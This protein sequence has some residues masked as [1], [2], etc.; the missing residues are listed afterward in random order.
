MPE[1]MDSLKIQIKTNIKELINQEKYKEAQ[2]LLDQYIKIAS[3][4][5]ENFSIQSVIYIHQGNFSEAQNIIKKGL[6]VENNNFELLFNLAYVFEQLEDFSQAYKFYKKA[7][8][9]CTDIIVEEQIN[10]KLNNLENKITKK[11]KLIFFIKHNINSFVDDIVEELSDEYE[12]RFI[13]VSDLRQIDE[14]MQWADL[15]W[16]EWCDELVAYGSKLAIA[17][18]KFI[19]CR[20]HSYEAF[21]G[22]TNQVLWDS[23]DKVIFVAEHIRKF[24]LEN[25]STLLKEKTVVIPNGIDAGKY[26]FKERGRGFKIAYVGYIN[27]KKGPML[28]LH[29]FKA[30]HDQDSRYKLYMA[31]TFQ[32]GRDVLYF[33]QMIQEWNLESSVIYQGWQ[34]SLDQ[35]LEDKNYI[36]CTSLLES[37]NLSVMQAMSKGIKPLI[38]NFVGAREIYPGNYIWST[39]EQCSKLLNNEDYNSTEYRQY[40]EDHYSLTKQIRSTRKLLKEELNQENK[41]QPNILTFLQDKLTDNRVVDYKLDLYDTTIIINTYNRSDILLDDLKR[42]FKLGAAPKLIVNDC[43]APKHTK[44]IKK[45]ANKFGVRSI[46]HHENN[47]GIAVARKTGLTHCPTANVLSLDD[48]DMLFC[49]D[50]AQFIGDKNL[51]NGVEYAIVIPRYIVTLTENDHR[52]TLGI[53]YDWQEFHN[54][55]G[56]DVLK[57]FLATGEMQAFHNGALYRAVEMSHSTAQKIFKVSEDY[58]QL[59]RLFGHNPHKKICVSEQYV[60]VRRMSGSSLTGKPDSAKLALNLLSML[61]A[62][63]YCLQNELFTGSQIKEAILNRGKLLQQAYNYGEDF[64]K[65]IVGYLSTENSL[66]FVSEIL[67]T[68]PAEFPMEFSAILEL[69]NG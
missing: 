5:V 53:Q 7:K 13:K 25:T 49:L 21:A 42:G 11:D 8:E 6:S 27:Y 29:A 56:G 57:Y 33:K 59:S 39:I 60:Y 4:D 31:G 16:F 20:L 61:V 32:D 2:Q 66:D 58:V 48:D 36:I 50:E 51:I 41:K 62:G 19:V 43:S 68:N 45:L 12:T 28:L 65:Q 26:H 54:M 34:D 67:K 38:H 15:C 10:K 14:G 47:E 9:G 24:V 22:Y 52:G 64:S 30:I 55:S 17:K 3:D 44:T 18:N 40:I 1:P 63:Y 69:I 37:Q 35:W 23:V 46:I